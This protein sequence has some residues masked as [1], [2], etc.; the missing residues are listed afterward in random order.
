MSDLQD[1]IVDVFEKILKQHCTKE[2]VD[3]LEEGLW[4]TDLWQVIVDNELQNIAV[5]EGCGGAGGDIADLLTLYRLCGKYAAPIPFVEHTLANFCW[6]A[7]G[8]SPTDDLSTIALSSA[9]VTGSSEMPYVPWGRYAKFAVTVMKQGDAYY[10]VR[11][12]ID[13][14]MTKLAT[15][16]ATEPRDTIYP[17]GQSMER[18]EISSERV[19]FIQKLFTAAQI[20]RMVGA[21]EQAVALS[22]RFSKEREQFGRPIHRFQLVQQHLAVLAG[23]EAICTAALQNLA[24]VLQD[25]EDQFEVAFATISLDAA[26]KTVAASA[27]QIHA[28]IGVTYE[29][30][31]HHFT[32]RLWAWRDE[33]LSARFWQQQM[34]RNLL[35]TEQDIWSYLTNKG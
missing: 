18:I 13:E 4:A 19:L 12:L 7:V 17:Y 3:I 28:A 2:T 31:L 30:R 29:H 8:G 21:I 23:E 25:N 35:A 26:T 5:S 27:H 20:S 24:L 11:F 1:M 6:E 16:L 32:R 22:I 14:T 15:N 10:L 9:Q 34:A 33:G